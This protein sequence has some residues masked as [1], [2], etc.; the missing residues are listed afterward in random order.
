MQEKLPLHSTGMPA[1]KPPN[2]VD[3][4]ASP[5]LLDVDLSPLLTHAASQAVGEMGGEGRG[6]ASTPGWAQHSAQRLGCRI[7]GL[8]QRQW[9]DGCTVYLLCKSLLCFSNI[10]PCS[11]PW[12]VFVGHFIYWFKACESRIIY[13]QMWMHRQV[14]DFIQVPLGSIL[15]LGCSLFLSI[16]KFE[17]DIF[18]AGSRSTTVGVIRN[19]SVS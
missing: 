17:P 12:P 2:G 4:A 19:L 5:I 15:I 6:A 1:G 11:F 18:L 3:W 9:Q 13:W 16:W 14:S 7:K 8:Q 10:M